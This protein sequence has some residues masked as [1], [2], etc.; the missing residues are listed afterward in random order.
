MVI[1]NKQG[2]FIEFSLNDNLINIISINPI[3]NNLINFKS[4]FDLLIDKYNGK[5]IRYISL[6]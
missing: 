4:L 2:D 1:S 5:I 6:N 3:S